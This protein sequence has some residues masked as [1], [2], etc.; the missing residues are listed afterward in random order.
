[1]LAVNEINAKGGVKGKKIVV[2]SYDDAGKSQ[3]AG[4]AVTA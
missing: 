1:M 4:T 2:K 3:E